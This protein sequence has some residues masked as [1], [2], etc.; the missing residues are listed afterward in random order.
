V[1]F[2]IL[3]AAFLV[4]LN[5][6][7]LTIL[8][9][10]IAA[11]LGCSVEEAAWVTIGPLFTS[12]IFAPMMG[13]LADLY[14]RRTTIWQL[15]FFLH[16]CGLLIAGFAPTIEVLV[17]ARLLTGLAMAC[18]SPTGFAIMV[19]GLPAAARGK[20]SA[21]QTAINTI[22]ESGVPSDFHKPL[23]VRYTLY[24][25]IRRIL[26]GAAVHVF[27]WGRPSQVHRWAWA[28]A[29]CSPRSW[30]G[31]CCSWDRCCR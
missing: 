3:L 7:I 15:G 27:G 4:G 28:W 18:D 11:E 19:A 1:N 24:Y 6:T 2:V 10:T 8:L 30:A 16:L 5:F 13:N 12:V 29:G 23:P 9:P 14:A 25:S 21:Y 22:G 26:Q 20:V 17:G 31:A